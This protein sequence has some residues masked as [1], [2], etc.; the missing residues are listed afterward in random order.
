MLHIQEI[1]CPYCPGKD[2]QKNG[3]K[4]LQRFNNGVVNPA[5]SNFQLAYKYTA[6]KSGIKDKII[7]MT[8]NNS[9]VR[10][11]GRVLKISKGRDATEA[12][13]TFLLPGNC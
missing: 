4:T 11:I 1:L 8:L 5:K 6:R 3:R 12:M 2:L 7:E 10:D 9:G 13:G